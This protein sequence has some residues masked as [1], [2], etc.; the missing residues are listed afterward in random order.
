MDT[1][2]V[3]DASKIHTESELCSPMTVLK[4]SH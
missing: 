3:L 1:N 2:F 4:L